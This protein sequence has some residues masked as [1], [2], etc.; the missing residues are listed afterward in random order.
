MSLPSE[1]PTAKRKGIKFEHYLVLA[2]LAV[3]AGL[4]L[5]ACGP[6]WQFDHLEQRA[7]K[8]ITA[9]ELQAWATSLLARYPVETNLTIA[10]LGTNFPQQL[11]GLAPKLGPHISVHDA[12]SFSAQPC[13]QL[14][15]GSGFL[16][17][18]G[19]FVG[20]TNF[21]LNGTGTEH[22]WSPGVYFYR[23]G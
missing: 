11:E 4:T 3:I 1:Q 7:K 16:G 8:V 13:V 20:A 12:G 17:H 19:F 15:W 2:V 6:I 14:Y 9:G 10:Q 5:N 21:T 23:R 22:P 18:K